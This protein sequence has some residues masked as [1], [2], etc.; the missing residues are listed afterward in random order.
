[1]VTQKKPQIPLQKEET[2]KLVAKEQEVLKDEI[3]KLE[4]KNSILSSL[5]E[6]KLKALVTNNVISEY[7]FQ[8]TKV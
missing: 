3:Q 8:K 5:Q 6:K 2:Q 7:W 4:D 1:M